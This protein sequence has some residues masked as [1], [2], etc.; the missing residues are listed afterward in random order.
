MANPKGKNGREQKPW[1]DAIKRALARAE[2]SPAEA[3]RTINALAERLLELGAAGDL[4]ALREIADRLDGKPAQAITGEDG[5]PVE[6]SLG[7]EFL[8]GSK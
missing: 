1:A 8:N 5:G 3:H 4:P 2:H 7:I 6:L